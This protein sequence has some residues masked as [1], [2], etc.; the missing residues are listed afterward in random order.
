MSHHAVIVVG[1]GLAALA[2]AAALKDAGFKT[3]VLA[4]TGTQMPEGR[5]AQ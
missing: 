1:A 5:T 3:V 4:A 2:C